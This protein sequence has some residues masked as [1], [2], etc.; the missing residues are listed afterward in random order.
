[1]A[2]AEALRPGA[3]AATP[4][5]GA[6]GVGAGGGGQRVGERSGRTRVTG[7]ERENLVGLWWLMLFLKDFWDGKLGG[8]LGYGEV[9]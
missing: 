3:S 4:A 5:L 1:M 2:L 7:K 8:S 9:W 6:R